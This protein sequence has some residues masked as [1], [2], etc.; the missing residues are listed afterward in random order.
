MLV[1]GGGQ[2]TGETR[3]RLAYQRT[4]IGPLLQLQTKS[5]SAISGCTVSP[6][7]PGNEAVPLVR[8]YNCMVRWLWGATV[9]KPRPLPRPRYRRVPIAAGSGNMINVLY[10]VYWE[11][12]LV[13]SRIVFPCTHCIS[14]YVGAM[15][16]YP[17]TRL[18]EA[19]LRTI[20]MLTAAA[21]SRQHAYNSRN[22]LPL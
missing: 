8:S 5:W 19:N 4:I 9:A 15:A 20:W 7:R 12:S 18:G 16:S 22:L 2:L 1:G 21:S 6:T 17:G 13:C 10:S 3:P 14:I 11:T